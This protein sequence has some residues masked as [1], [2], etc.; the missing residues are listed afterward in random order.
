MTDQ[1][2]W[3]MF[4]LMSDKLGSKWLVIHRVIFNQSYYLDKQSILMGYKEIY[5]HAW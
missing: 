4:D 1:K 2:L 3:V 5:P